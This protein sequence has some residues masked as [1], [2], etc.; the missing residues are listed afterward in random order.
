MTIGIIGLGLLG[1]AIAERLI[2]AGHQVAGYDVEPA[3]AEALLALGGQAAPS[4]AELARSCARLWLCLPD[5]SVVARVVAEIEP[6][7]RPGLLIID[8]TTGDPQATVELAR[9]LETKS[10]RY[11]DA[12]V[13]GSSAQA[14]N[15]R[16]LIIAGGSEPDVAACKDLLAAVAERWFHVGPAGSGAE[17]KLVLNLV[18]GL[19]RAALAEG[20]AFARNLGIDPKLALDILQAGASYSRVMD[21]KGPKMLAE[22]FAPEARLEQHLKDVG[23]I[24]AAADRANVRLPLSLAH[25]ELL[26]KARA[27]GYGTSDNSAVIKAYD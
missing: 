3:H 12:T 19:N 16:V 21:N 5:S 23:L 20:L 2:E 17:M 24:L 7:L 6:S 15:G 4:A 26:E 11:V 27:A 8:S 13:L 22:D 18:L 9:G 10:V 1:S 14:R 25:R